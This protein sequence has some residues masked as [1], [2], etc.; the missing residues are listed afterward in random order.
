MASTT[1]SIGSSTVGAAIARP[2]IRAAWA[3]LLIAAAIG[4]AA[5]FLAQRY[6]RTQVDEINARAQF[7]TVPLVVASSALGKGTHLTEANVAIRP[8][9][10]EWAHSN[11]ITPEQFER[12]G[13]AVL[14]YPVR[15]GEPILWAQLESDKAP[16]FSARL[17]PGRRA[18][19]MPIDE[20]SSI[21]GMVQPG[22]LIDLMLTI[23]RGARDL[24]FILQQSVPVLAT[25]TQVEQSGTG[26]AGRRSFT[27]LTLD[28]TPEDAKRVIAAREVGKLT[29]LLR[30]PGD[31]A[32]VAEARDDAI[33]LLGLAPPLRQASPLVPIIYGGAPLHDV[34]RLPPG[35]ASSASVVSAPG[36][37]TDAAPN[38]EARNPARIATRI[39]APIAAPAS[40]DRGLA[41]NR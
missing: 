1:G 41:F 37:I 36:A 34:Q 31:R 8:V 2:P 30:A 22:D 5:T 40:S 23:R 15:V 3:V 25:G 14:A 21:S 20:V 33:T 32:Q 7:E 6:L 39:A 13:N 27:T 29:A 35:T 10:R 38:P 18:V 11:A 9:P 26:E 12:I 24:A 16:T 19:T 28:T 4:L 17:A